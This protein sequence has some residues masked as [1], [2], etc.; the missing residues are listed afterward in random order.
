MAPDDDERAKTLAI[1]NEVDTISSLAESRSKQRAS[2]LPSWGKGLSTVAWNVGS[3][4]V[5][6][7]IWQFSSIAF[8]STFFP[9]P[10]LIASA[11]YEL[12]TNGDLQGHLLHE[13][14]FASLVRVGLGFGVACV[15]AI[16]LGVAF[17][18]WQP[19]YLRT[20]LVSE[21]LRFI[22]PLAWIPLAI[23]L[24]TG[25]GRY[26]FLIWI[27]TFFP[28]FILTMNAVSRVEPIFVEVGKVYGGSRWFNVRKII[29]PAALPAVFG[30]MRAVIGPA[31]MCIVAAEM[32]ATEL[33][34]LGQ[35]LYNYSSL[36]RMDIVFVAMI[37]I[38]LLG[39]AL[40]EMFILAERYLFS[41]A[42]KVSI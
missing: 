28:L 30:G 38:G 31:W 18:L 24:F 13:H 40:N 41:Y 14:A 29:I 17:G 27:G 19:L 9:G 12:C 37:S 1:S 35:L 36:F 22:P 11:F 6:L 7:L 15:T 2:F 10:R 4:V 8:E 21:P 23:L 26:V 3:L 5:F 20:R 32:L 42:R 33:L 34:G 16:P 39:F 25:T